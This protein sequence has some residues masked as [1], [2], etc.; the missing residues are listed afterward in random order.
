MPLYL[1]DAF[2]RDTFSA[3][4]ANR[5]DFVVH[6][7]HSYFVFTPADQAESASQHTADV[8]GTISQALLDTSKQERRNFVV[9]EWSCALSP[10]SVEKEG[11]VTQVRK[12]FCTDQMRVYENAAA[13]WSFWCASCFLFLL[14][15]QHLYYFF[16]Q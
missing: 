1:H 11:D 10:Q 4:I 6:D 3:Y 14:L 8:N 9:D 16:G 7:Y 15:L 13:G 5:T 12:Q 2:Q